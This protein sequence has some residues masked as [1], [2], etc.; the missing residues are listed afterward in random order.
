MCMDITGKIKDNFK[1]QRD[2]AD[3]LDERGGKPCAPF[4]LKVKDRKEVMR[5][6][7][8]LKF[9]DGY[10]AGL[11]QCVNVTARKIHG[12]KSHD[13]HIIMKRLLP[14]MLRGYLDDEIWEALAELSYFY[15]QLYAKEIKKD[16][17][18]KLEKEI[19]CLYA[20]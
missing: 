20:N 14:V 6:M 3:E 4:V 10:A 7:K 19:Q 5:W 18:K 9:P 2:I 11:K 12:L 16:M 1:A 8:R 15:R 17:M 13:Y